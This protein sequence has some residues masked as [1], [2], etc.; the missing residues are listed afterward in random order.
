[1]TGTDMVHDEVGRI[2]DSEWPFPTKIRKTSPYSVA[3]RMPTSQC[4]IRALEAIQSF[5]ELFIA[6]ACEPND[7]SRTG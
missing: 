4:R 2:F 7:R 5:Y 3:F 6:H 1:M